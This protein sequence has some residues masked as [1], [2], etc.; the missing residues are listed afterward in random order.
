M[1]EGLTALHPIGR[2]GQA[3]EVADAV[4]WLASERSSFVTGIE[5]AVD[6]GLTLQLQH[7]LAA[8]PPIQPG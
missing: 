8:R 3:S 2:L 5:L 7:S 6:G 4:L 1:R